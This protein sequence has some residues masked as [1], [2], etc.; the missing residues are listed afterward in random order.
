MKTFERQFTATPADI[1]ELGHVNNA[2]WVRWVQEISVAHWSEI[3]TPAQVEAYVW[4]IIRHEIDYRGNLADGES[5]SAATWVADAPQGA[6]WDRFV[7]FR[8]QGRVVVSAKTTWAVL[9]RETGRLIRVP[10]DVVSRFG[11]V[12]ER[13]PIAP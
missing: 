3:A 9:D 5:V 11:A 13:E 7:E 12:Q 2:V 4:V 8:K 6:K 1:D 10:K